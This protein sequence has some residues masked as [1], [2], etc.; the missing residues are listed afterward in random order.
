MLAQQGGTT[1][2]ARTAFR[3]RLRTLALVELALLTLL[4]VPAAL[5]ET[6][7]ATLSVSAPIVDFGERVAVSGSV[8]TVPGC[9]ADRA[10][11]LEWR[12]AD[13]SEFANV[14][15]GTTALD[16]SF[17]FDQVQ[18]HTGGYRATLPE[19]GACLASTTN[20]AVVRVRALV[21]A[22]LVAASTE[23]GYCVGVAT[24]VLPARPGPGVQL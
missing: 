17:T 7:T 5:A 18:P 13:S 8:T 23:S 21:D 3:R 20:E 2:R 4:L 1:I 16:G 22:A 15:S 12:P 24:S 6:A 11:T 10:V 9:I 19:D 14:A